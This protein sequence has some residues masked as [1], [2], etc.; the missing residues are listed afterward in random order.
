VKKA[1]EG[2]SVSYPKLIHITCVAHALHRVYEIICVLYPNVDKFVANG[3]KIFVKLL[4]RREFL[5]NKAPDTPLP[6]NSSNYM[7]GNLVG[8]HCVLC[9]KLLKSFA[10][11]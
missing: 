1:A 11:W 8:C 9:R 7:V 10:L 6:P 5:K 3:K 4:A 2:L